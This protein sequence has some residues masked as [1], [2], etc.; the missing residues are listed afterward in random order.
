MVVPTSVDAQFR[1]LNKYL[2]ELEHLGHDGAVEDEAI[3][4]A[5]I[6]N[7]CLLTLDKAMNAIWKAEARIKEGRGKANVYFP[8]SMSSREKLVERLRK[9]QMPDIQKDNPRAFALID[10]VQAYKGVAWLTTLHTIARLRHESFPEV[11]RVRREGL[12]IGRGQDLYIESLRFGADGNVDFKGH[13]INR[14]TGKIEPA[15]FD[16]VSEVR[17]ELVGLKETPYRFCSVAV[18][19]VTQLVSDLYRSIPSA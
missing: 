2:R 15:N 9:D 3:I 16:L 8:I 18:A 10:S 19:K 13:G 14:S 6:C 17:S 12:G 4:V 5:D 7:S 11:N 1:R